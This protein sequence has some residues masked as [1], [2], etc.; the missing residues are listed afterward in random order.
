MIDSHPKRAAGKKSRHPAA[1]REPSPSAPGRTAAAVDPRAHVDSVVARSGTSFIWGLRILPP[2]RR[3]AMYAIYAFCREVDDIADGPGEVA[4]KHEALSAWREEIGRLYAGRPTRPTT[5]A[6]LQPVQQFAL[7]EREFLAVIDGMEVDAAGAVQIQSM[8]DL[9][10]YCRNVAGAVGML[11]VHA[12][13]VPRFPGPE[14]ARNLGNALQITNI[15]RDLK[16]D[17]ALRRLYVP[18]DLLRKHGVVSRRPETVLD[19]PNFPGVCTEL[20]ETARG[21]YTTTGRLLDEL[22]WRNMR[23]AMLMM[24]V[25]RELLDRLEGH[26]W[27]RTA[28]AV[29]LSAVRKLWLAL[30][31]GRL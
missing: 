1:A 24:A 6:L 29:R 17:A 10:G 13:G 5:Q 28:P 31:Y 2:E 9:L 16:E 11:S 27:H 19:D 26:G 15:L 7:P 8:G 30:R 20:A 25:Y 14:I 18:V 21:Y 4:D 12:F 23:P 22:G 3:R